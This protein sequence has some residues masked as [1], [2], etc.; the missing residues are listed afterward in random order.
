M[1]EIICAGSLF[2]SINVSPN[3][4]SINLPTINQTT[5]TVFRQNLTHQPEYLAKGKPHKSKYRREADRE[6]NELRHR[7]R[8]DREYRDRYYRNREEYDDNYRG[9]IYREPDRR[10]Q[11]VQYDRE[12]D[13]YYIPRRSR[14]RY[15]RRR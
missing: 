4:E 8:G 1:L 6:I 14:Q 15:F 3:L 5:S 9:R 12:Q 2:L 10:R 11:E 7:G 13:R